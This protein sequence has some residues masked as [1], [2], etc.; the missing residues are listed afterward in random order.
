MHCYHLS[1][2]LLVNVSL[3]PSTL[4]YILSPNWYHNVVIIQTSW[5]GKQ[6]KDLDMYVGVVGLTLFLL[7]DDRLLHL[8]VVGT[9]LCHLR[10]Q[11]LIQVFRSNHVLQDHHS[12]LRHDRQQQ[13]SELRDV[14][15]YKGSQ[16]Y[17][18]PNASECALANPSQ[19]NWYLIYLPHRDG[20]LS[21]PRWLAE[22][23]YP[24]TDGH[25][26]LVQHRVIMLI[27]TNELLLSHATT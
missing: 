6:Y 11:V 5:C 14:I 17:L 26:N 7:V 13:T 19:S 4:L 1:L 10:L 24:T 20:R 21:W 27:E 12:R 25:I 23:V 3:I 18:P 9:L 2:P 15:C 8:A 22:T 16:C